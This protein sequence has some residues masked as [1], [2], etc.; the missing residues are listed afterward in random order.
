MRGN[1]L[2]TSIP[3]GLSIPPP[4]LCLPSPEQMSMGSGINT[5]YVH[6]G[7]PTMN[8]MQPWTGQ[9][10]MG[11]QLMYHTGEMLAYPPSPLVSR[12]SS[13]SQS[14]SPSRNNS[15]SR[16]NSSV[17]RT[18]SQVTQTVSNVLSSTSSSNNQTNIASSSASFLPP[19]T[20][21]SMNRS[22][23]SQP[24]LLHPRSNPP[25][26]ISTA[27]YTHNNA[28][29]SATHCSSLAKQPPPRLRSTGFC[30]SLRETLG[31]EM[32]NYKG[33]L[34]NFTLDEVRLQQLLFACQCV[35]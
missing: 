4:G 13:P 19:P 27:S 33:N 31:K 15:P 18:S 17:A 14:R 11:N 12:Q 7:F 20:A 28:E 24:P 26:I 30:D 35:F 9:V 2:Y 8:H 22:L 1:A 10:L 25:P 16:K 21:A 34:Q 29:I 6:V 5:Q 3:P 23:P 32:P